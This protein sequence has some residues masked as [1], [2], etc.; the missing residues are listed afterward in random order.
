MKKFGEDYIK[1]CVICGGYLA[2][3]FLEI[4]IKN[5]FKTPIVVTWKDEL[6]QRDRTLL[7]KNTFYEDVFEY[8][9]LNNIPLIETD[10]P[11]NESLVS[12]LKKNN[13]NL[14]FPIQDVFKYI[15]LIFGKK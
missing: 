2:C 7:K 12:Y 14:V 13:I 4:L 11:N 6:H 9:K 15:K 8:T 1:F 3:K 10:S 5:K